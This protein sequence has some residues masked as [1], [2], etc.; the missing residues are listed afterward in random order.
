MAVMIAGFLLIVAMFVIRLSGGDLSG[1]D[2]ALPDRI[3]LPDATS[4]EAFT[5]TRDWYAVVTTDGR[6]LIY[7]RASGSLRQSI[8]V[9]PAQ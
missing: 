3:A 9:M 6:I 8:T 2:L 1:N 4:A 7:D 5:M